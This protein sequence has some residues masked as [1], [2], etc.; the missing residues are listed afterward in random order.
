MTL[1][2]LFL[3]IAL[4]SVCLP[5]APASSLWGIYT[6]TND[7]AGIGWGCGVSSSYSTA[8]GP[9]GGFNA[10]SIGCTGSDSNSQ[11]GP[12]DYSNT[13][14][15]S[16]QSVVN[17]HTT[18]ENMSAT[19]DLSSGELHLYASNVNDSGS[20]GGNCCIADAHYF[21][22]IT[23]NVAGATASTVTTVSATFFFDG[24]D[25]L[26]DTVYIPIYQQS[27]GDGSGFGFGNPQLHILGFEYNPY[28][29][30]QECNGDSEW[31]VESCSPTDF[32][33]TQTFQITGTSAT[34]PL[35]V[36][37]D[38]WSMTGNTADYSNTAGVTLSLPS[39]VTIT[40]A[41][42]EFLSVATP[43]PSPAWLLV[44]GLALVA[45]ARRAYGL[46]PNSRSIAANRGSDCRLVK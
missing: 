42:G 43:E 23:F 33:A 10:G 45:L 13:S 11:S 15:S 34:L 6:N 31:V 40:S 24:T 8:S 36:G 38:I 12:G 7:N 21:D 46:S 28:S 25:S 19:A 30:I 4:G 3:S 2:T 29:H 20:A 14:Q 22:N 41:S 44:S 16:I 18:T 17:G 27:S 1:R 35:Y 32:E 37:L 26:P 5:F 39:N 9:S